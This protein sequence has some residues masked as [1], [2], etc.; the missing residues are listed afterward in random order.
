MIKN[1]NILNIISIFSLIVFSF[2]LAYFYNE[3][4]Q[5]NQKLSQ[6]LKEIERQKKLIK[7]DKNYFWENTTLKNY[8]KVDFKLSDEWKKLVENIRSLHKSPSLISSENYNKEVCSGYIWELSKKL[9]WDLSPYYIGMMEQNI[10]KTA[11][12][13]QLPYSYEFMWWKILYDFSFKFDL[14]KKDFWQKISTWELKEFFWKA[15]SEQALFGDIGFLYRD[16]N[17]LHDLKIYKNYNSHIS[18]NI[19][20]SSF[21]RKV[22][23]DIKDKTNLEIFWEAF[24]CDKSILDDMK[25]LLENY[26]MRLNSKKIIFYNDDFYYLDKSRFLWEKLSFK[27]LD[28]I[29]IKDI[30]LAH[31]FKWSQVNSLFE[32]SCSWKFFP[33]NIMSI[34]PR[35]IEK[36]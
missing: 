10:K 4:L 16:T 15:F 21:S 9:W 14:D 30:S 1:K 17:Y 7:I 19:W 32:M 3:S 34:N 35:F 24:S 5:E 31:F 33:I 29:E 22:S 23:K 26:D 20:V 25:P 28:N 11:S 18:K 27:Y 36:M 2:T 6:K 13:W 8:E 12:A